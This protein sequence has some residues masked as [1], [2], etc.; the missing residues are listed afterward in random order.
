MKITP[1]VAMLPVVAVL[2]ASPIQAGWKGGNPVAGGQAV[3]PVITPLSDIEAAT[4]VFM[5]EEEKLARDVYLTLFDIWENP[6]FNNISAAEQRHMDNM[7]RL[8]DTYGLVDPVADDSVGA[9]TNTGLADLY[10]D[11]TE[12]GAVS[13]EDALYAGALV[14]ELDIT[15]LKRAI[16]ESTHADVTKAYENLMRG[17]RNHLRAFVSQI[18][19]LGV[20]YEAQVMSQEEVDEIINSA[21]ERGGKGRGKRRGGR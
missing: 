13:L 21:V 17:S 14:E 9:F 19:S 15:D 20:V 3:L 16:A 7:K 12:K 1:I 2:A 18:E 4:L 11:L 8:L 5:R 6:V 10:Q